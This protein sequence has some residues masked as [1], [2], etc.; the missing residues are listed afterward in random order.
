LIPFLGV[1]FFAFPAS[2]FRMMFPR[3]PAPMNTLQTQ[4]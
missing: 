1:N 3:F 2:E 4:S